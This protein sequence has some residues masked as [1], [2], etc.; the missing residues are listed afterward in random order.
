MSF[1]VTYIVVAIYLTFLSCVNRMNTFHV[2]SSRCL[3]LN[4]VAL[5]VAIALSAK[6]LLKQK[7]A[8]CRLKMLLV[9]CDSSTSFF[10]VCCKRLSYN[11]KRGKSFQIRLF[12]YERQARFE[13]V[14]LSLGSCCP[15]IRRI[16]G[17]QLSYCRLYLL[18]R[19]PFKLRFT[20]WFTRKQD[21]FNNKLI[22]SLQYCN[23]TTKLV[24]IMLLCNDSF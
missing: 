5:N 23:C 3:S 21:K 19:S 2:L 17:N 11:K 16:K 6:T 1:L 22:I 24:N 12:L 18:R 4:I 8:T 7:S 10:T 15:L 14:T 20:C 9:E 13:L